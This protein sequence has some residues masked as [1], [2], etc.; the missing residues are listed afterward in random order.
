MR[1]TLYPIVLALLAVL[2]AGCGASQ[3]VSRSLDPVAAAATNTARLSTTHMSMTATMT[4]PGLATPFRMSGEGAVDNLRKRGSM[5]LDMS[6]MANSL[7]ATGGLNDPSL[8]R[9]EYLFD[10]S[11]G[12][13]IY[14]H[15]PF[16][17]RALGGTKS[18][19]R[20]DIGSVGRELGL[21]LDQFMQ[22]NQS[23]PAQ[24]LDF[25]RAVSGHFTKLGSARVRG[26]P[27]TRY[28]A[29]VDIR[30][31]PQLVPKSQREVMKKSIDTLVETMGTSNYPVEVFIDAKQL[32][33]RLNLRMEMKLP[34]E[35]RT[36]MAMSMDFYGFGRP[37]S[38]SFPQPE[39]TVDMTKLME[40]MP[41]K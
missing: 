26:V 37:V 9:G 28:R 8:W 41:A 40:Q 3:T 23:N 24:Q 16:M 17:T 1:R 20:M 39:D 19:V 31:Y 30:K 36:S 5:T 18:W 22:M 11:R 25:L 29:S 33:R 35:G 10:F 4:I 34:S 12:M 27:T 6:S 14:M 13:V 38:V 15:F 32:V 21:N 7:P 2:L